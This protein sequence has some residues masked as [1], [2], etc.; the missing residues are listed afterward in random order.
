MSN[1][2]ATRDREYEHA[3]EVSLLADELAFWK[4][5]AVWHRAIVNRMAPPLTE[6]TF[7]E[8]NVAQKQ[9]NKAWQTDKA[10]RVHAEGPREIGS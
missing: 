6:P 1:W 2:Q 3:R 8:Q 4:F 5:Q 7:G 10:E 9:L